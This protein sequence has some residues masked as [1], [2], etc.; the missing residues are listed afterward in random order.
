M[1]ALLTKQETVAM[2]RESELD[3]LAVRLE[4]RLD[5]RIASILPA[6]AKAVV[7]DGVTIDRVAMVRSVERLSSPSNVCHSNHCQRI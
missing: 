5:Q 7:A 3:G 1:E 2:R 6:I 4:S